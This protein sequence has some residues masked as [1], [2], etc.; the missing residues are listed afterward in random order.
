MSD[1]TGRVIEELHRQFVEME[2]DRQ[3]P[4]SHCREVWY[5]IHHDQYGLCNTCQKN[6]AIV[7]YKKRELFWERL[8]EDIRVWTARLMPLVIL[9]FIIYLV[10]SWWPW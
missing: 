9:G 6:P 7:G 8:E 2:R 1:R 5:V 4:C 3:A 10:W